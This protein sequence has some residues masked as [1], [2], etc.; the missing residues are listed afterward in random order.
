[1]RTDFKDNPTEACIPA[2][3]TSRLL[4]PAKGLPSVQIQ[5]PGFSATVDLEDGISARP[6]LNE[7]S[8]KTETRNAGTVQGHVLQ[9]PQQY[10][11]GIE[12]RLNELAPNLDAVSSVRVPIRNAG[13][14]PIS[15]QAHI[16]MCSENISN[17]SVTPSCSLILGPNGS[18]SEVIVSYCPSVVCD[19]RAFHQGRLCFRVNNSQRFSVDL[20]GVRTYV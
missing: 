13:T 18:K 17:F 16:L 7:V 12:L 9:I 8:H 2:G 10:V 19:G 5:S 4:M 14:N 20:I 3:D 6:Q 11:G 15:V 1:M